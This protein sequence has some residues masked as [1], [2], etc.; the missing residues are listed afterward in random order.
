M[1]YIVFI[2]SILFA[3]TVTAQG[4][5][6]V[7]TSID[8][9]QSKN[10]QYL[11][12][13]S[14]GKDILSN[15]RHKYGTYERKGYY[16]GVRV[17][18][19][20]DAI[21]NY[22]GTSAS[23]RISLKKG[24]QTFQIAGLPVQYGFGM[25]GVTG[26]Q[27][28]TLLSSIAHFGLAWDGSGFEIDSSEFPT[29]FGVGEQIKDSIKCG[30]PGVYNIECYGAI[31]NDGLDDRAAIQAALDACELTG[32]K[33]YIP[34][35]TFEIVVNA[36]D[37]G[38]Y[39]GN[40]TTFEGEGESSVLLFT[41]DAVNSSGGILNRN[42]S[43][44][45]TEL[46]QRVGNAN[47]H[48]K[49]FKFVDLD[50]E[51]FKNI[52]ISL[53]GV[54]KGSIENVWV[55]NNGGYSIHIS[56]TNDNDTVG[57]DSKDILINNCKITG[58]KD[59]GIEI[60][61][62]SRVKVTNCFISGEGTTTGF[63]QA[64]LAWNGSQDVLFSN[65]TIN[66]DTGGDNV[67]ALG[68]WGYGGFVSTIGARK[69]KNIVFENIH[70]DA[71]IAIRINPTIN[72]DSTLYRVEDVVIRNSY[73]EG[74]SLNNSADIRVAKGL[75]IEGCKFYNFL[76]HLQFTNPG[77][78]TLQNTVSDVTIRNNDFDKGAG[79]SL[80]Y[81]ITDLEVYGN[82]FYNFID[83]PLGIFGGEYVVI[84]SNHF[85]NIGSTGNQHCIDIRKL[86]ASSVKESTK[87]EVTNNTATDDRATKYTH[88]LLLLAD[89]TDYVTIKNND[90][91]FA[92]S[93]AVAY[94]NTGTG[95]NI[96]VDSDTYTPQESAETNH[97]AAM[98]IY[99]ATFFAVGNLV[100]VSGRF[101][102]DPNAATT[103]TSFELSLPPGY[104][105]QL[106]NAYEL[107]GVAVC[108]SVAGAGS[109][110]MVAEIFAN[111]ASNTAKVQWISS[112][113]TAQTWSYSFTYQ[114]FPF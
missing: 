112:D 77:N 94:T 25:T 59:Q 61:G 35:D 32:G 90:V 7:Q 67:C 82:R 33:V 28:Y 24:L 85:H 36:F 109:T 47:I 76:N 55:H 48:L 98:T 21:T 83:E 19:F 114:V 34:G 53:S 49:N 111:A 18:D 39:V 68:A 89:V 17:E 6:L 104:N 103:L 95:I 44:Q 1:K 110:G 75:V 50:N 93:T 9:D 8:P 43:G 107:K 87:I 113:V 64:L 58:F 71:D 15:K 69:T 23:N 5:L 73:F 65:I 78:T 22:L 80:F 99:P 30:V 4:N 38:V 79:G 27:E 14:N 63:G 13:S 86:N 52:A 60:S 16:Y 96:R 11:P 101:I 31:A 3:V 2:L 88:N 57:L 51:E 12:I 29:I 97:A 100:T 54:E 45:Y 20:V 26:E 37:E 40:N 106:A 56:R 72:T 74:D 46:Q 102:A 10:V 66:E 105:S 70:A 41:G 42:G 92:N 84:K 81:G 91:R 108:G 62:A